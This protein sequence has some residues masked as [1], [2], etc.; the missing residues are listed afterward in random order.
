MNDSMGWRPPLEEIGFV[1]LDFFGAGSHGMIFSA[2]SSNSSH[3]WFSFFNKNSPWHM[4]SKRSW[5]GSLNHHREFGIVANSLCHDESI[6]KE[7]FE[8][9]K[10]P[11]KWFTK[12]FLELHYILPNESD[13]MD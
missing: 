11:R 2:R 9:F 12:F 7:V 13:L 3:P 5:F 4:V 10:V 8:T 1:F 6:G